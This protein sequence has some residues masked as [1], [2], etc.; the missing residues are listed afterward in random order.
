MT[1]YL[2]K[3]VLDWVVARICG[4]SN[5][6]QVRCNQIRIVPDQSGLTNCLRKSNLAKRVPRDF[7]PPVIAKPHSQLVTKWSQEIF[8]KCPRECG[9]GFVVG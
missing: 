7:P 5:G 9:S 3:R 6:F 1:S 4:P 8:H 2:V